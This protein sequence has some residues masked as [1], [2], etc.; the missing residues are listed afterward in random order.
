MHYMY[1]KIWMAVMALCI[2]FP[3]LAQSSADIEL[4]KQIARQR[5]YSE[6]QIEQMLKQQTG[7]A[8]KGANIRNEAISI[9][10]NAA[11]QQQNMNGAFNNR[12]KGKSDTGYYPGF[13]M[14]GEQQ[15]GK[16]DPEKI[17][18]HDIFKNPNLDFVPNYNIPTPDSYKLSAGDEIIID[19]WGNVIT[20]ITATVT[21]EGAVNIPE[22]G[23]V[24][25][26]GQTVSQAEKS[27]K[28][29]LSKIY[30]GIADPVPNT[31]V[32][33]SLG[34][35]RSITANVV[36][37]V[38]IPGSYTLPS[39]STMASALYL[40][41]GPNEIGTVR[42]IKL[43]RNNKLLS[44]FDVYDFITKGTFDTNLRL[45]DNDV[46][47][48]GPYS[49]IV[50]IAG[51]VKRPMRY[52]VKNGETLDKVLA[53]AGGFADK[54]FTNHVLVERVYS[55][56]EKNGATSHA[57]DVPKD[58]FGS[59]KIEGG[60][61]ITVQTN[62]DRFANKV[63]IGGAVW[64]PG[65]YSIRTDAGDPQGVSTLKQ[66]ITAAGGIREDA[67]LPRGYILRF[68]ENRGKEQ[69]SFS[70]QDVILGQDNI[71]LFPDDSVHIFSVDS[72]TPRQ[73]V[74]IYG[75]VNTPSESMG[76]DNK[77]IE[78]DYRKGMTLGDLILKAN[79]VTDAATLGRIEIAR[80]INNVTEGVRKTDTVALILHYNLLARPQDADVELKPYDMVFVRKSV[81]YN[82]QQAISIEGEVN[83]PGTYVIEK[84]TVRL[85]DVV[86]KAQGVNRDAYVK[87]AKL[88][89][90][91]TKEEFERLKTAMQI[92]RREVADTTYLD[93]LA[94]GEH[95][96]IAIDM[97]RAIAEPG[98]YAD[99]VLRAGDIITI[100][101]FNNTVKI[102]GAV[103]YPNTI[104]YN[105]RY[106][107]KDYVS[108]AGGLVQRAMKRKMYM[109]HMNGSVATKGS[110]GFVVQPGTEIVIPMKDKR[111]N[112][113]QSLAAIMGVASSTAS[114]AAMVVTIINQVNK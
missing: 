19:I 45:E 11:V 72:L 38:E 103:L 46:I 39:L 54:A 49:G 80:R 64:R 100:P 90:K 74:K 53:Y 81:S 60:D 109:V 2:S 93:S 83:Y 18:G 104:S 70:L 8:S 44:T 102:S 105:P 40:A 36:G 50:T 31:F 89:R 7:T 114:L 30:S 6:E 25:I 95:Y 71:E 10:R 108:N 1:N 97:E 15:V 42:E 68:G 79:G 5:G 20:N 9:D 61:I 78:Y 110:R 13:E 4:A 27:L 57:F 88:T 73:T 23:P 92:A 22:L 24:Y 32:K 16:E 56:G 106:T 66:L 76:K 112:N 101:K 3:L 48:V 77:V 111:L 67:Y 84:N 91:L 55:S 33:L 28:E 29:Y 96:T 62:P 43:Y 12:L 47:I 85:S 17:F 26:A 99:V 14:N 113:G 59:F 75:E 51:G 94:I 65:S 52:E 87:G 21:P 41:G 58:Q 35:I 63:K 86:A 98:S 107:W 82:P 69:V 37:D 34:K